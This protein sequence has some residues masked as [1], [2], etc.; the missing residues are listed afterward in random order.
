MLS[1]GNNQPD[2][3]RQNAHGVENGLIAF[4]SRYETEDRKSY[5]IA[6]GEVA[7]LCRFPDF[8]EWMGQADDASRVDA[9]ADQILQAAPAVDEN[10]RAPVECRDHCAPGR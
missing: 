7:G 2:V 10:S 8:R 9:V 6:L 4:V 3:V 1:P 5:F